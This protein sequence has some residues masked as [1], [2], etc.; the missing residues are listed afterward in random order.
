M[1]AGFV[2]IAVLLVTVAMAAGLTALLS[3]VRG[4][5]DA[6]FAVV[7]R[8]E[9]R[10]AARSAAYAMAEELGS[11]R[12]R[13][14]AGKSPEPAASA[15]LI[16]Y[17]EE[18]G[19][20]WS[21]QADEGSSATRPM[22]AGVDVNEASEEL[23]RA[24]LPD[25][26]DKLIAAR[27][28]RTPGQL[29]ALLGADASEDGDGAM[30]DSMATLVSVDPQVRSGAGGPAGSRGSARVGVESG[31]PAPAGLSSEGAA[32]FAAIADG[33][34]RPSSLGH[35]LREVWSRGVP[36]EDWD[37]L[38]DAV[39]IGE[40]GPRR[41]LIDLNH[42]SEGVLAALPGMDDAKAAAVVD[43]RE[44]LSVDE[45]AGLAWPVR[46]GV[47]DLDTYA[48][49][50]DMLTVRS[51][52]VGVRFGVERESREIDVPTGV[53]EEVPSLRFEGIVDLSGTRPRFVYLRDVTYQPWEAGVR[54][55]VETE[56]LPIEAESPD[57]SAEPI[58]PQPRSDA[59][60]FD[61]TQELP[62]E[63]EQTRVP[64]AFGRFI[65]GRAG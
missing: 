63:T 43:R 4:Q 11:M 13:A 10:L 46:E 57:E 19:W 14:L 47:L 54:E 33:T 21:V 36:A 59:P 24:V 37:L 38:V 6:V 42:A 50:V 48:G 60:P 39:V 56:A 31:A 35:I 12:D 1:R 22:S 7:A 9:Q 53:I 5:S 32:L 27:P 51:M 34:F 18:P 15:A 64:D 45:R 62:P 23:L 2:L 25:D 65:P 28:I 17:A 55:A 26:A 61:D 41:G 52:Q 49:I 44:S 20:V 16:R 30:Q 3:G 58:E 40:P 8:H 29:R